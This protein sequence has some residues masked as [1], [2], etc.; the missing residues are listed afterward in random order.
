VLPQIASGGVS[1]GRRDIVHPCPR[2]EGHVRWILAWHANP[3]QTVLDPFAGSCTTLIA[4][5]ALGLHAIGIEVHRPFVDDAI[6]RL[7][8]ACAQMRIGERANV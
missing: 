1:T 3:G 2:N 6:R 5:R 8:V 4:A 7:D